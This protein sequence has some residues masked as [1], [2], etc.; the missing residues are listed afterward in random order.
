VTDADEHTDE[1]FS[2]E[3][4]YARQFA[5]ERFRR[6]RF[7]DIDLTECGSDGALFEECTFAS[8]R[9]NASV[10]RDSAFLRCLFERSNLFE[11]E[12][13]GCKLIGSS[14]VE[15]DLRPLTVTEGD[16]S[17]VALRM[18]DLRGVRFTGVRMREVD[19]TEARCDGA[20]LSTVD[21]SAARLLHTSLRECDLRGSDLAGIDPRQVDLTGAVL[22]VAQAVQLAQSLGAVIR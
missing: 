6:C 11:A 1:V 3:D 7:V 5:G 17:F 20:V 16:W 18:A 12:F 10:H 4:W 8:V 2:G 9:F 21:L 19:L 22:G 14:F 13:T 15:S